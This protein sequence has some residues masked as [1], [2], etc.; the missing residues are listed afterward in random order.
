MVKFCVRNV[1][2]AIEITN[3]EDVRI[4][5]GNIEQIFVDIMVNKVN[6]SNMDSGT[7][8]TNIWRKML[9]EVNSKKK[10]NLKQFKQRFNRLYVTHCEFFNLL[11]HTRFGKDVETNKVHDLEET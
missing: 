10:I 6:K 4:W 9:L 7:F 1:Q 5:K 3:V 2:M 11:K 8:S